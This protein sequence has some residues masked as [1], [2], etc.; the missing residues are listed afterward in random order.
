[1]IKIKTRKFLLF[2][3]SYE[4]VALSWN[5]LLTGVDREQELVNQITTI[6]IIAVERI[7]VN[8]RVYD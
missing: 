3:G 1:M 5:S 7:C 6:E 2:A 4:S 8:D